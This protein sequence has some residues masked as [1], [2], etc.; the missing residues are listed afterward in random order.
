MSVE[1]DWDRLVPLEAS[2]RPIGALYVRKVRTAFFSSSEEKLLRA[3]GSHV[4][5]ALEKA[6]LHAAAITDELTGA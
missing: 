5:V 1:S 4:A 2:G 3:F 6:R